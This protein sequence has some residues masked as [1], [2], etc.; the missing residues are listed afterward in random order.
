VGDLGFNQVALL[1]KNE[2]TTLQDLK[3]R[4]NTK[5]VSSKVFKLLK[6]NLDDIF[7]SWVDYGMQKCFKIK[8]YS[9]LI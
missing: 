8:I 6:T 1:G 4:A 5:T 7:L 3:R 9:I 2:E